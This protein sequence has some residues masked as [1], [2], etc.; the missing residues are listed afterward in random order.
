MIG[1]EG[2]PGSGPHKDGLNSSDTLKVGAHL[3]YNQDN[4]K[5]HAGIKYEKPSTYPKP[6]GRLQMSQTQ[7]TLL[8]FSSGQPHISTFPMTPGG[9]L[10]AGVTKPNVNEAMAVGPAASPLKGCLMPTQPKESDSGSAFPQ[11]LRS[12]DDES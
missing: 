6:S 1:K 11:A 8:P 12:H 4:P 7:E 2:G 9:S 10:S 5:N 3:S